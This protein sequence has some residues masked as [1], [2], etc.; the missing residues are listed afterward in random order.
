[1][2]D[3]LSW[4]LVIVLGG[5]IFGLALAFVV[6]R[7]LA[8]DR[9]R[10]S[11][12]AVA[13]GR[14]LLQK[15]QPR[16]ALQ[17]VARVRLGESREAQAWTI[18]GMALAT[19]EEVGPA[20]RALERA[21]TLQ[22]DPMVAKV[23]AAIY[24]GANET[25]RGRSM[26]EAAARIDPN[27]F[28]PWYALGAMVFQR[29][30]RHE[31][32]AEA[33]R[34][35]LRRLPV[36]HE[37][38]IG[39]IRALL[40]I[41]RFEEAAPLLK[42]V[43]QDRPDDP[44]VLVLAAEMARSSGRDEEA[45]RSVERALSLDADNRE[46]LLL[47]AELEHRAGHPDRALPDAERAVALDPNDLSALNLLASV[48][49]ALG[50]KARAAATIARRRQVMERSALMEALTRDLEAHPDDPEPRWRLG[51]IA[52]EAGIIPLASQSYQVALDLDPSCRP[53]REG[54][55]ALGI[56]PPGTGMSAPGRQR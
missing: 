55:T 47:R 20:R 46:G 48:E 24:L 18:R 42:A 2:S 54:L 56:A 38:R 5:T 53:A 21:W 30:G 8:G 6:G 9:D 31:E 1:M 15:G 34:Q 36:H 29:L 43:L 51:R 12:E 11:A 35:A 17:A 13:R 19:L 33:F 52:A 3:R 14:D 50:L 22:P 28:R 41:H 25:D 7:T 44:K 16:W 39:L 10:E 40:G 27:D 23:L 4:R 45:F 49:S 26:L 32:A 37:S